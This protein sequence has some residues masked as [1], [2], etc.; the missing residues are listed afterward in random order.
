MTQEYVALWVPVESLSSWTELGAKLLQLSDILLGQADLM[1][2]SQ[3]TQEHFTRESYVDLGNQTGDLEMIVMT[4]EPQAI[5]QDSGQSLRHSEPAETPSSG[6][7]SNVVYLKSRDGTQTKLSGTSGP[8]T[9]GI[10]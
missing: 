9:D 7:T 1:H 4:L 8:Y 10:A 6:E 2:G 3:S 5:T